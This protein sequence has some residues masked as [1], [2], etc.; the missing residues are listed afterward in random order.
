MK[1]QKKGIIADKQLFKVL[2]SNEI[3]TK[4]VVIFNDSYEN[5]NRRGGK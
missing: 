3:S 2:Y 4:K 5:H 1:I